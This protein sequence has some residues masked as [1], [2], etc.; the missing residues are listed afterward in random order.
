MLLKLTLALGM[1]A[2][3]A[4]MAQAADQPPEPISPRVAE[5]M[6]KPHPRQMAGP[7]HIR[8]R[9]VSDIN[10]ALSDGDATVAREAAFHAKAERGQFD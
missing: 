2:G 5:Q 4:T 8:F 10:A 6:A 3:T 9:Q 1:I 7:I